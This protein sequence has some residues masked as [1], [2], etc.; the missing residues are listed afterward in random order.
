MRKFLS[1]QL[2]GFVKVSVCLLLILS[3]GF[4]TAQKITTTLTY[5]VIAPSVKT[6]KTPVLFIMHGY[7]S[8]ENDFLDLAKGVDGRFMKF[9]LRAPNAVAGYPDAYCWYKLNF[10]NNGDFTYNYEEVKQSRA[11]V[12]SFIS[13][14]CKAYHLD[15]TQV[16]I[17]GF[18]Q[19]AI[20]CY[21]L[22]LFAPTKIKGALP[23]SGR[24]MAESKTHKNNSADLAKLKFF[25]GHGTKD[26]RIKFSESEKAN[27]FLKQSKVTD[28]VFKEYNIP[29][30]VSDEEMNDIK[31]WL[32]KAVK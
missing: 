2:A 26:E 20:M 7:G 13:N 11:K 31:N 17:M 6:T 1:R 23:V 24:M 5:S 12:L 27:E 18:S 25:I 16:F 3:A 30:S 32:I 22:A 28:I 21:E 10:L 4:G 15:S 19:G 9:S 29:H 14:A 8:N